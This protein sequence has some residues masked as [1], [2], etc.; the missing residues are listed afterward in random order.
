MF[1]QNLNPAGN[2]GVTIL[3]SA[4]SVWRFPVA[5][6]MFGPVQALTG[7]LLRFPVLLLPSLNS[8]G[9][10]VGKPVA[11]QP[12]AWGSRQLLMCEARGR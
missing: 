2:I 10:E 11:P 8:V 1:S 9:A 7:R 3:C 5:T 6:S 12:R 4:G